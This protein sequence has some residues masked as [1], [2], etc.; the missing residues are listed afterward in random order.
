MPSRAASARGSPRKA[1]E[2]R[3]LPAR[4]CVGKVPGMPENGRPPRPDP[5]SVCWKGRAAGRGWGVFF[6]EG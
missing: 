5:P 4:R 1:T 2:H 3:P 6:K